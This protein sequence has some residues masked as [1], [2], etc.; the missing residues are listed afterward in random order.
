L[1]QKQ[2]EQQGARKRGGRRKEKKEKEKKKRKKKK[3]KKKRSRSHRKTKAAFP[4][5]EKICGAKLSS[6]IVSERDDRKS[7]EPPSQGKLQ[8]E[9]RR[10]KR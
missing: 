10:D 2:E 1:N 5:H 3:E 4:N 7:D 8:R 6:H 9:R